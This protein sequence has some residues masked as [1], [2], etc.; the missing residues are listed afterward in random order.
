MKKRLLII[1]ESL[2]GNTN[3]FVE[4]VQEQ[5]SDW[6]IYV[7]TPFHIN[8]DSLMGWDKV[9]L[10][11][12]TWSNGKIP[13]ETKEMVIDYRDYFL[14]QDLLIFGSGWSIYQ[15]YCG[16]VDGLS[17]ILD[18]KFPTVKFELMY[19]ADVEV[20]AEQTLKQFMEATTNGEL[21]WQTDR[22]ENSYSL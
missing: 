11:C 8:R 1:S 20:E 6:S 5:Y 13:R 16:A 7:M 10:G 18:H 22:H 3:S 9:M 4:R 17:I 21:L 19:D 14:M 15:N 2:T 12:Y